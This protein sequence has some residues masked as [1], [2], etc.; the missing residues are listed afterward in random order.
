[1]SSQGNAYDC[2]QVL[3]PF[4][5]VGISLLT[6]L[7]KTLDRKAVFSRAEKWEGKSLHKDLHKGIFLKSD[8]SVESTKKLSL[9]FLKC[10][11]V[12]HFWN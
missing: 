8:F 11:K 1:M 12:V 7:H 9:L 6:E 4:Y 5:S 10:R 3:Q 2:T